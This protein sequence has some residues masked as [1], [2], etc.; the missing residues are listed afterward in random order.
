MLELNELMNMNFFP[1]QWSPNGKKAYA[2][3]NKG[4]IIK[5]DG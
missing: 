4:I 1:F 3:T 5:I 2:G